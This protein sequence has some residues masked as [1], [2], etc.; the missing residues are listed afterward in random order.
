MAD[1][2]KWR[3]RARKNLEDLA[4]TRESRDV[5]VKNLT[6]AHEDFII[7]M[8][9][10]GMIPVSAFRERTMEPISFTFEVN[11]GWAQRQ[12]QLNL[13]GPESD[14]VLDAI[15]KALRDG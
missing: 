14:R 8:I 15:G 11:S 2:K 1:K 4:L 13:V 7:D 3:E 5:Q 9:E 12:I 10:G 6:D